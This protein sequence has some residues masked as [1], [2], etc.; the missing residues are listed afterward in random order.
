MLDG[1]T[2]GG[3]RKEDLDEEGYRS[4]EIFT[5]EK[6]I[7]FYLK[8]LNLLEFLYENGMTH[9]HINAN[10]LRITDTYNFTLSDFPI[11]NMTPQLAL[12]DPNAEYD[13]LSQITL[14]IRGLIKATK[15]KELQARLLAGE[16]DPFLVR[17][18]V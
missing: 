1:P 7:Y 5:Q 9:G 18:L 3:Y 4:Q 15:S 17:E 14:R 12:V 8:G 10:S 13:E 2:A 6:Y 16:K 11:V